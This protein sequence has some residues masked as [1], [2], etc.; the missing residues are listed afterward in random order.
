MSRP[1]WIDCSRCGEWYIQLTR[2]CRYL[3]PVGLGVWFSLRVREVPGSN[4]GPA[5]L[6]CFSDTISSFWM[7][8]FR[9]CHFWFQWSASHFLY[10]RL[11]FT[12]FLL[13][14]HREWPTFTIFLFHATDAIIIS[15]ICHNMCNECTN[16]KEKFKWCICE[17][18][19]NILQAKNE[20]TIKIPIYEVILICSILTNLNWTT[21][22]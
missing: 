18:K 4:P 6:F 20:L 7:K 11:N 13:K 12:T 2:W 8:L 16:L 15:Y 14:T 21:K 9:N 19:M 17:L 3:R 1:R 5:Q 22:R 10:L